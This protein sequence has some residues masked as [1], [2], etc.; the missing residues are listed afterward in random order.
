MGDVRWKIV[1]KNHRHDGNNAVMR[2]FFKKRDKQIWVI[3]NNKRQQQSTKNH[4]YNRTWNKNRR[5]KQ[6][7]ETHRNYKIVETMILFLKQNTEKNHW[8]T[9]K[10]NSQ[11]DYTTILAASTIKATTINQEMLAQP[12]QRGVLRKKH[13][14]R[15]ICIWWNDDDEEHFNIKHSSDAP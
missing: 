13:W 4:I 7:T 10:A 9:D 3:R 5:Q 6:S 2:N 11:E 8:Y 14:T 1:T 12:W 15:I